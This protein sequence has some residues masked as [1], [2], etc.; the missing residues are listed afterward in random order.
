MPENSEK[1]EKGIS[2]TKKEIKKTSGQFFHPV[3]THNHAKNRFLTLKKQSAKVRS[4]T[5]WLSLEPARTH[6]M[7]GRKR[8]PNKRNKRTKKDK[9]Q[10]TKKLIER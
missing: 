5:P 10:R 3:M 9:K 6:Y 7:K 1:T 2:R 4:F 8:K